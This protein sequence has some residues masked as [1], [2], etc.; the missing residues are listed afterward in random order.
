MV[1]HH[2][3][4]VTPTHASHVRLERMGGAFCARYFEV[5][6]RH[7][8]RTIFLLKNLQVQVEVDRNY[9]HAYIQLWI[10]RIKETMAKLFISLF[11]CKS[12]KRR[13]RWSIS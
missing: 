1:L 8:I 2:S 5:R 3:C 4:T 6:C 10:C 7:T 13:T 12:A 11:V 9:T